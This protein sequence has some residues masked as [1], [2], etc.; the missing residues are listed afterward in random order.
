MSKIAK[1]TL[2]VAGRVLIDILI[3]L[4]AYTLAF[5]LRLLSWQ[6]SDYR[7]AIAGAGTLS[8]RPSSISA[9]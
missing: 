4:L 9:R 5:Q 6:P 2:P 8:E 3:V 1:Q 7:L